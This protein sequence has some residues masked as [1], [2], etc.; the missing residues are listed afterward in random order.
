[1]L[2]IIS[3]MVSK[4]EFNLKTVVGDDGESRRSIGT[5][6]AVRC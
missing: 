4:T 1:M 2:K 6:S 3:N 5:Y